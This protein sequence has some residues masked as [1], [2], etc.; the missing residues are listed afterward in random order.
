MYYLVDDDPNIRFDEDQKEELIEYCIPDDKYDNCT[1]EFDEWL[2][3][4]CGTI[5]ICGYN[6]DASRILYD[7]DQD[8]Y[9]SEFESWQER[10]VESEREDA[11]YTLNHAEDRDRVYI[12][13][14]TVYIYRDEEAEPL[15]EDSIDSVCSLAEQHIQEQQKEHEKLQQENESRAVSFEELFQTIIINR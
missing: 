15:D 8:T 12:G 1:D 4:E 5:D 2:N 6:Y 3:D 14:Y 10:E 9:Y 7:L 13:E 11:L